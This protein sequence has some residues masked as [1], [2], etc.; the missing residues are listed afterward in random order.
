MC[1]NWTTYIP[2]IEGNKD[3]NVLPQEPSL[4]LND[5]VAPMQPVASAKQ[6]Q[7]MNG[8]YFPNTHFFAKWSLRRLPGTLQLVLFQTPIT[9]R[10]LNTAGG[11]EKWHLLPQAAAQRVKE[12]QKEQGAVGVKDK[13]SLFGD[14]DE[15]VDHNTFQWRPLHP[16]RGLLKWH[17][18]QLNP[19]TP[20]APTL[21]IFYQVII[22]A[23]YRY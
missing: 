10:P 5:S 7:W 13:G 20:P 6:D 1:Q 8:C 15:W 18:W 16:Q 22:I 23:H 4:C 11:E 17:D 9:L 12:R 19:H 21:W 3:T 2:E 14:G